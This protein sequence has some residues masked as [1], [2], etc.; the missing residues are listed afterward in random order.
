MRKISNNA[1]EDFRSIYKEIYGIDLT[2][3]EAEKK[4][5]IFLKLMKIIY[6]PI[7]K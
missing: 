2:M 4:A 5:I 6:R 7:P 3:A 1:I